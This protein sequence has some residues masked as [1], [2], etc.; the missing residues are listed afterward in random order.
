M[1][2]IVNP[3]VG[4]WGVE[5]ATGRLQKRNCVHCY[6]DDAGDVVEKYLNHDQ[7]LTP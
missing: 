2:E 1:V 6:R 3:E 5:I 7:I 4:R